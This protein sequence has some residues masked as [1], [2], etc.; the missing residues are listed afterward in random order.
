MES[1]REIQLEFENGRAAKLSPRAAEA[2]E[3]FTRSRKDSM[4]GPTKSASL[5]LGCGS[6]PAADQED[7]GIKLSSIVSISGLVQLR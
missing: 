1:H 2:R 4:V 5:Q 3:H 6:E 7:A